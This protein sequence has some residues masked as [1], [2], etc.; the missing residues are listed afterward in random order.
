MGGAA[1]VAVG[2][3][4]GQ[5][6]VQFEDHALGADELAALRALSASGGYYRVRLPAAASRGAGKGGAAVAAG[7]GA[8]RSARFRSRSSSSASSAAVCGAGVTD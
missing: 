8:V 3:R 4:G 7:G 1:G 2:K 5:V 6:S